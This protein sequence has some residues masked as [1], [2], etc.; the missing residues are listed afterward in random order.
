MRY[1]VT[2]LVALMLVFS[3]C[4][5]GGSG[6]TPTE[7]QTGAEPETPTSATNE[8]G[9]DTTAPPSDVG[10]SISANDSVSDTRVDADPVP[11]FDGS[12]LT[13]ETAFESA[14]SDRIFRGHSDFELHVT[15][16][17]PSTKANFGSQ[18]SYVYRNDT[19]RTVADLDYDIPDLN[20]QTSYYLTD[21]SDAV[22]NR[23]TGEIRYENGTQL[24]TEFG[25]QSIAAVQYVGMVQYLD[26]KPTATTTVDGETAYV[27]EADAPSEAATADPSSAS[28]QITN[29]DAV[30]GR[31]VVDEAGAVHTGAIELLS[32]DIRLRTGYALDTGD[33]ITVAQPDWYDED[34]VEAQTET[35]SESSGA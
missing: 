21:G 26:W 20:V 14:F 2:V 33:T 7:T 11:G 5:S 30:Y 10:P 15:G 3:G 23:T 1:A 31:L 9:N 18:I 32:G 16:S 29:A 22:R 4:S 17:S 28:S 34:D 13:N 35:E 27:L 24:N 19:E 8:S 12:Q 6:G 25:L